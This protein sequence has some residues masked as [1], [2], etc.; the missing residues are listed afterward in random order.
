MAKVLLL[1]YSSYGHIERMAHAEA[2]GARMA[3]AVVDVKRVPELSRIRQRYPR[4]T[5]STRL[6]QSRTS[7]ISST[8][9]PSYLARPHVSVTWRRR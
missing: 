8:T 3:G 2:E 1:Y 4:I 6:R 7:M 5:S 9:T